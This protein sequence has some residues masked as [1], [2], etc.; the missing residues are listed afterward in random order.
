[1]TEN[2]NETQT[3]NKETANTGSTN[4]DTSKN[5]DGSTVDNSSNTNNPASSN[6]EQ[7]RNEAPKEQVINSPDAKPEVNDLATTGTGGTPSEPILANLSDADKTQIIQQTSALV[8]ATIQKMLENVIAG[9]MNVD[10][11]NK[12]ATNRVINA[13]ATAYELRNSI[14]QEMFTLDQKKLSDNLTEEENKRL[15]FLQ[16]LIEILKI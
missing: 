3:E 4:P 7:P 10:D 12:L 1:M 14:V 13:E 16:S 9:C 15:V 5:P 8:S 11:R 6:V 2:N